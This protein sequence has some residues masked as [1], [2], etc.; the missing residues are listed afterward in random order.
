MLENS[1]LAAPKEAFLSVA[2]HL[3]LGV[4]A[5]YVEVAAFDQVVNALIAATDG[6]LQTELAQLKLVAKRLLGDQTKPTLTRQLTK[7]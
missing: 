2:N 6:E 1:R 3:A 7:G 4:L 5:G